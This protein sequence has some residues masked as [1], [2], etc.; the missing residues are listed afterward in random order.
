MELDIIS[1]D[2]SILHSLMVNTVVDADK[3]ILLALQLI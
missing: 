2:K 3:N 1:P